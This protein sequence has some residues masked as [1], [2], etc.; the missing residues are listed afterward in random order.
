MK[1]QTRVALAARQAA[2]Q[3]AAR[4]ALAGIDAVPVLKRH[5]AAV[6]AGEKIGSGETDLTVFMAAC[7]AIVGNKQALATLGAGLVEMLMLHYKTQLD[8]HEQPQE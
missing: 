4:Q 1:Q 6:L 5:Y 7:V 8:A 2:T 3:A